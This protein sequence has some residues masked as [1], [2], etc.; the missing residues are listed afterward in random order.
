MAEK[1]ARSGIWFFVKTR[2][3]HLLNVLTTSSVM[4]FSYKPSYRITDSLTFRHVLSV[5]GQEFLKKKFS[6]SL[7]FFFHQRN[8]QKN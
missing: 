2:D 6:R 1:F 4:I 5:L 8:C 7:K 3:E